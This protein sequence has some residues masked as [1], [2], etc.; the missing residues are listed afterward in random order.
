MTK[1]D[2]IKRRDILAN[3]LADNLDA[4]NWEEVK[5]EYNNVCYKL[6]D[7]EFYVSDQA[8][9]RAINE[10]YVSLNTIKNG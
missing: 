6:A 7:M 3:W 8:K 5:D 4:G 2:L 9:A 1:A 10:R